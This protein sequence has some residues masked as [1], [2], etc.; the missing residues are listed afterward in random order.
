MKVRVAIVT[1]DPGWH[2]K[3]LRDAFIARGAT[4]LFTTLQHARLEMDRPI[5]VVMPGFESGLPDAV[6]VRGI[7]G[8]SLQQVVYYLNI[9]HILKTLGVQVYNDG[10]AIERSVDKCLTTAR[11]VQD[12]IPTP[13]TWVCS[14]RSMAELITARETDAGHSLI[15]KP[16]FGSQGK[17][18]VRIKD[19]RDLPTADAIH[20]VWYLQRYIEQAEGLACDWRVFVIAGVAVAAM[21]RS[22]NGW[23]TNVAQG[24]VCHAALPEGQLKQ[25]AERAVACLD[26]DYAGVDLMCDAQGRW[27]VIEVNSVPAWRG[28]Q[29]VTATDI[30]TALADDLLRKCH[31]SAC[32]E[33]QQ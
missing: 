1:D 7:P 6:F 32:H 20:N 31:L 22:T 33:A 30:A 5:R 13:P 8:G 19:L 9:L 2:G 3:R 14:E 25:L 29:G 24:G 28:L 10:R 18:I 17:G 27:W 11:L 15:C 16:L 4:C 12:K 21:R 26:M 23:L